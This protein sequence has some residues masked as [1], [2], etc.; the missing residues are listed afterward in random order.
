MAIVTQ[1]NL[2][3]EAKLSIMDIIMWRSRLIVIGMLDHRLYSDL[4]YFQEL[5][6]GL[7]HRDNQLKVL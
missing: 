1:S 7:A 4:F 3:W 2:T 5:Q 6:I